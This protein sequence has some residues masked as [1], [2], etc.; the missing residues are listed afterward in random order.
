MPRIR[1]TGLL[2]PFLLAALGSR[3]TA[4][5]GPCSVTPHASWKSSVSFPADP[6]LVDPWPNPRWVK[7]TILRCDPGRVYFQDG[8][9]FPFHHDFATTHLD[10]L[11][12]L[13]RSEFDARTLHLEGQQAVLG[14]VIFPPS[15]V[16]N[17]SAF[18]IQLVGKDPY[19]PDDV[20]ALFQTVAAAVTGGGA[21][22]L[23]FPAFEQQ[24]AAERDS[25]YLAERGVRIGS[26]DRW[27]DGNAVYADGWALG[28]LRFV[29]AG[30]IDTAYASG[31]LLPSDVLLTD[32]VPAEVPFVQGILS[33][34]PATPNSHV[35]ILARSYG[36]P[37]A[38]LSIEEDAQRAQALV[39]R[40][41]IVSAYR[42]FERTELRL[43]DV[44]GI[45]DDSMR[46]EILD[47]KRLPPL[48]LTPIA[49][50][51]AYSRPVA[52]L[53]PGDVGLV[54]G[55]AA[56]YGLL[57]R[58]IPASAHVAAAFTFDVWL[59]F[60]D[61]SFQGGSKHNPLNNHSSG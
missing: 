44:G 40:E 20:I 38:Y 9:Q 1:S 3:A 25:A 37:F 18:G 42:L 36:V 26:P 49:R 10:P 14:A 31:E 23:Y 19:P 30:R 61:Q 21:Q 32:G 4:G 53:G 39:G 51:G 12:G 28:R 6:F 16:A 46:S 22:A 57:L 59:E 7:F 34:A 48:D 52:E 2:L 43:H 60:L 41:V 55:K 45:L 8:G 35:A 17:S 24:A 54:G 56:H 33:L 58:A 15:I 29:G 13:T 5:G 11:R 27:A 47:L 50:S